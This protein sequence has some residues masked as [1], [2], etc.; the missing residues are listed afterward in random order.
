MV[1][2]EVLR[3][4]LARLSHLP[5][6]DKDSPTETCPRTHRVRKYFRC[7]APHG[8][9]IHTI[10]VDHHL[11]LTRMMWTSTTPAQQQSGCWQLVSGMIRKPTCWLMTQETN[12]AAYCFNP[13]F[14]PITSPLTPRASSWLPLSSVRVYGIFLVS[15]GPTHSH[16]EW[17][18]S[19][20][21][22]SLRTVKENRPWEQVRGWGPGALYYLCVIVRS[23]VYT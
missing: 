22:N 14:L 11:K 9:V 13:P 1:H 10:P 6:N 12:N 17:H 8:T 19:Q 5:R 23:C 15:P 18:R 7:T 3:I 16:D 21:E 4:F 20:E 2:C